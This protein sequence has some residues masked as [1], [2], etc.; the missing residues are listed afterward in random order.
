MASDGS[1]VDLSTNGFDGVAFCGHSLT[2]L[3]AVAVV[4]PVGHWN[5]FGAC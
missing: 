1:R 5:P 4:L 3:L 2:E